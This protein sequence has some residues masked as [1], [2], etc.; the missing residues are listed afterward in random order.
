[1][2]FLSC[3]FLTIFLGSMTALS[4]G[5]SVITKDI[6]DQFILVDQVGDTLNSISGIDASVRLVLSKNL[7][8]REL[9][10]EN[11]KPMTV[12]IN[13]RL[14]ASNIYTCTI[15]RDQIYIGS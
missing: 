10:I 9:L 14:N 7:I 5:H 15:P 2:R 11:S 1:M 13:N 4:R 6:S 8:F 12:W 3:L